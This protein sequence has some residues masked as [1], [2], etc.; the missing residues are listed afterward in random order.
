MTRRGEGEKQGKKERKRKK[1]RELNRREKGG[2]R[3]PTN[4]ECGTEG[5]LADA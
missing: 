2:Q 1:Y 4:V 5:A 3:S